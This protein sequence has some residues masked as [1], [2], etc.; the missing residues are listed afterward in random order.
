MYV[1]DCDADDL[2]WGNGGGGKCFKS[3][4]FN[5]KKLSKARVPLNNVR[6]QSLCCHFVLVLAGTQN[7][8]SGTFNY[9]VL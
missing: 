1:L 5:Q 4:S 8:S 6:F 3:N 2:E 9:A 7:S